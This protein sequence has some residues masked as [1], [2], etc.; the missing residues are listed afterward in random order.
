MYRSDNREWCLKNPIYPISYCDT[1][2]HHKSSL[3]P[4][5]PDQVRQH[6][7]SRSFQ[8]GISIDNSF[9]NSDQNLPP[10]KASSA[11]ALVSISCMLR[12][13]LGNRSYMRE[14]LFSKCNGWVAGISR[15]RNHV[16]VWC[17][18]S[19]TTNNV[20]SITA[21]H[22]INTSAR[23][24]NHFHPTTIMKNDYRLSRICFSSHGY[25]SI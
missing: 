7:L 14:L 5:E 3:G 22:L 25:V 21:H 10:F 20:A 2:W 8:V 19:T 11:L 23:V 17:I 18:H 13:P 6:T 4:T 12:V 9:I 15:D 16:I 1:W 24:G